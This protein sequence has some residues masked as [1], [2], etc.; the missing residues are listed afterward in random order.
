[1]LGVYK[2][3]AEKWGQKDKAKFWFDLSAQDLSAQTLAG[4]NPTPGKFETAARLGP[5]FLVKL[6]ISQLG[7]VPKWL[8][9]ARFFRFSKALIL[10]HRR[11]PRVSAGK[12]CWPVYTSRSAIPA[13]PDRG[14]RGVH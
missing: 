2:R 13:R 9:V 7:T 8:K 1:M 3:S 10:A 12:I 11:A 4:V 6:A 5:T 14:A